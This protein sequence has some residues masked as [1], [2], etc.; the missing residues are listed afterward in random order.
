MRCRSPR[1]QS[2]VA[3]S[4]GRAWAI[5]FARAGHQISMW[6]QSPEATAGVRDYIAG[7]LDDL[8]RND[9]LRGQRPA[10]VLARV[11]IENELEAVLKGA[12]HVQESTPEK[13]GDQDRRVRAAGCSGATQRGDR[14]LDICTAALGLHREP[15]RTASLPCGAPDQPAL[16]GACRRSGAC[17]WTSPETVETT[18]RFLLTA[19]HAHW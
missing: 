6:D 9:L 4:F 17:A 19:G 10:E 8:E 2:S 13:S 1:S 16:P 5:S 18:R 12:K 15:R 7:V 14:E 11:G 3:G